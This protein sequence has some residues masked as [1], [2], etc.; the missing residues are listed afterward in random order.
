[1]ERALTYEEKIRKAEEIYA[2]RNKNGLSHN[3]ATVNIRE[4]KKKS[5]LKKM[6]LQM[7][8]CL[9]MYLIFY[10]IQTTDYV[11]S[12]NVRGSTKQILSYDVDL[13]DLY[14][15]ISQYINSLINNNSNTQENN[16][17]EQNQD[18]IEKQ[19]LVEENNQ[20]QMEVQQETDE[21]IQEE[22]KTNVE[23]TNNQEVNTTLSQMEID[24]NQIKQNYSL[25]IPVNGVI[26]SEF[27]EREV[28]NALITPEH[29]GIDIAANEG[30]QIVAS[31][32]GD[33]IVSSTSAT[34]RKLYKNKK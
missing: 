10:L 14:N 8:I 9:G 32:E 29:Y 20:V 7:L 18:N 27:G 12:E 24:A 11:F 17:E 15:T 19:N 25:I 22:N 2:R 13:K 26:S 34:Y 3:I 6:V 23:D 30:T 5:V 21:Q 33:V 28:N 16:I 4:N 31:M 1:M